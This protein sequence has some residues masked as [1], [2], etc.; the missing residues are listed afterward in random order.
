MKGFLL[1]N[2]IENAWRISIISK[3]RN[4]FNRC[5]YYQHR[6]INISM[7]KKNMG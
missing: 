3:H 4:S 1:Y 6:S 7:K 5:W 2:H